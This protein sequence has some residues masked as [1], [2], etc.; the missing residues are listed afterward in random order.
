MVNKSS[1]FEAFFETYKPDI[2]CVTETWLSSDIPD[3]F[4]CPKGY[5][6]V[7]A[8]RGTRGGGVALC[9]KGNI[10]YCVEKTCNQYQNV[11]CVCIDVQSEYRVIGFYRPPS[12]SRSDLDYATAS[13]LLL[14]KLCSTDKKLILLGDFNLPDIDWKFYHGPENP[15]YQSFIL[16]FNSYGFIQHVS[17][18]TRTDNIL[19]LVLTT[20]GANVN[21]LSLLPPIC[22]S[23][24]NVIM[25]NL[26]TD[27]SPLECSDSAEQRYNW[28]QASYPRISAEL[29]AIDWNSVF[30]YCFTVD[31]CWETF[32]GIINDV[33]SR[34]VPTSNIKSCKSRSKRRVYPNYIKR[35]VKHKA[36]AWKTWKNTQLEADK[37]AYEEIRT[38]LRNSIT[39]F[40]D[41]KEEE[42]V[43]KN[44]IK[45]FYQFVNKKISN[46]SPIPNVR[47]PDGVLTTS[48]SENCEIF[49]NY[50]SSVFTADDGVLQ[51]LP[52]RADSNLALSSVEFTP[53]KVFSALRSLR[54]TLSA[55][56]D[57]IHNVFLK[58][59][60]AA[61][62]VPLCHIF[63]SSMKDNVLP[64]SWKRAYVTPV[65]KKG[66]NCDPN[67][68]RPISLTS[69]CCKLMEKIV[70]TEILNYLTL[71]NLLTLHQHGFLNKKS[72]ITNLLEATHDWSLSMEAKT[73]S[74]VIYF[75]LAKAFDSVSHS[76]LMTKLSA[77][78]IG[79]NLFCWL[80]DFLRDRQQAVKIGNSLS[81]FKRVTS[82]T[83]QGSV[84]GPSLF[85]LFINDAADLFKDVPVHFKLFAD[86]LKIYS[87]SSDANPSPYLN[88]AVGRFID[89][90]FKW[91][92]VISIHKCHL[93]CVRSNKSHSVPQAPSIT[94]MDTELSASE[95][96][97]DLG[98]HIDKHLKFDKHISLIVKKA[99][100]RL[101]LLLKCFQTKNPT[102]LVRAFKT[103][104]RPILDY[105]SP[106]WSPHH[107]YLIDKIEKV[108]KYF[109]KQIPGMRRL[110]YETRLLR[111]N[112]EPLWMRRTRTDLKLCYKLINNHIS[113]SIS[114][115]LIPTDYSS[116]RGH[117]CKLFKMYSRVD[118]TKYHFVNRIVDSWNNLPPNVV[119]AA[120]FKLFC[121]RL[122]SLC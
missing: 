116:T 32:L 14:R 109:T 9:V 93:L 8:D 48:V 40:V 31:R 64:K 106:V 43:R 47:R 7:R 51:Q 87:N 3:G 91:Q 21:D 45:R 108:Q 94:L 101:H 11:E 95:V 50:F 66:A 27:S 56:P 33:F 67:N 15:I 18:P 4:V 103:Y 35:L 20:Y 19:D 79:G 98:I 100:S 99:M 13:V 110:P 46:K 88:I 22:N 55:G 16:F 68:Y 77:Y 10:N 36:D 61:L 117:T 41:A 44:N 53:E 30:Q 49:N 80:K 96:V 112:I 25:F 115:L 6:I 105:G 29:S 63:D 102:L 104:V 73:S 24:H 82:G 121:K 90:C 71:N 42:L 28:S 65:F 37:L 92:L 85:L 62:C 34:N 118:I 76:K 81:S 75:D 52:A 84:L 5:T 113:S 74:H 60:A 59:C 69:T 114:E 17:E 72:T 70:N 58:N 111:L 38:R 54:P 23:D 86:D 107:Q 2:C 39:N 122:C 57:G 119:A 89:W 26:R 12:F 97:C 83:I 78:N 120:N 1:H